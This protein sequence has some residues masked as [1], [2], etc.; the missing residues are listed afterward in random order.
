MTPMRLEP[1][2]SR[3]RVKHSTTESLR[4]HNPFKPWVLSKDETLVNSAEPDQTPQYAA[5]DQV[6]RCLLREFPFLNLNEVVTNTQHPWTSPWD[7]S[8]RETFAAGYQQRFW[9]SKHRNV[10]TS[11][12]VLYGCQH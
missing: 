2:A 6:L 11:A 8:H 3:S 5:S 12:D 9:P 7:E 4:S 10:S 1:A